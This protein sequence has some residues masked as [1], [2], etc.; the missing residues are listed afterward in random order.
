M[1]IVARGRSQARRAIALLLIPFLAHTIEAVLARSIPFVGF[2]VARLVVLVGF[3]YFVYMGSLLSRKL[4]ALYIMVMCVVL[5]ATTI[6]AM[7][8]S[9][10]LTTVL[11]FSYLILLVVGVVLLH[12]PPP[13]QFFYAHQQGRPVGPPTPPDVPRGLTSA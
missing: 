2:A 4:V 11:E 3:L 7:S 6:D 8:S 1:D 5:F 10:I 13:V 9:G 12:Y